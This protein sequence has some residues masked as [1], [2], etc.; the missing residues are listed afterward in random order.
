[1][2]LTALVSWKEL[3]TKCLIWILKCSLFHLALSLYP[4]AWCQLHLL[5]A[6]SNFTIVFF[7]NSCNSHFIDIHYFKICWI[8]DHLCGNLG[9]QELKHHL[10]FLPHI[11][12]FCWTITLFHT[13]L[14]QHTSFLC[15]CQLIFRFSKIWLC[16]KKRNTY[17]KFVTQI[18]PI[19][20]FSLGS[21]LVF[22]LGRKVIINIKLL[23]ILDHDI[24]QNT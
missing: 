18:I 9:N 15:R 8:C 3:Y 21:I 14:L 16:Y 24:F 5:P 11:A 22:D 12:Q 20:K 10:K 6:S 1:M 19:E 2:Q 7:S 13:S 4:S 23:V 17:I